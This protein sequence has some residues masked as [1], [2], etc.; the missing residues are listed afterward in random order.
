LLAVALRDGWAR[1]ID[2]LL[3]IKA[4]SLLAGLSG[5]AGSPAKGVNTAMAHQIGA[6]YDV[7][8]GDANAIML[9]HTLR[10][11]SSG[12]P[13]HRY[14]A[15]IQALG[16]EG[17]PD[18]AAGDEAG[19]QVADFCRALGVPARLRDVGVPE[20]GLEALAEAAFRSPHLAANPRPIGDTTPIVQLLRAAW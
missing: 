19:D 7:P 2:Y 5:Q 13:A 9:P 4:A 20:S 10:Y 15:L 17:R 18:S 14:A 12:L 6:Q 11:N 3:R 8:H 1:D 16:A